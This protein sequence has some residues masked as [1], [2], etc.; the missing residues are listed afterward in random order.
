[1][2]VREELIG[3]IKKNIVFAE[4]K[5]KE[6]TDDTRLID[7]LMFDSVAIIRLIVDIENT[8]EI[9]FDDTDLLSDRINKVGDLLKLIEE[10]RDKKNEQITI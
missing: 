7:D 6:I 4:V 9:E 10:M 8:F 1:M 3:L 2:D 5:E